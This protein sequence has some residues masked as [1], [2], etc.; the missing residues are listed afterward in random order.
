[1]ILTVLGNTWADGSFCSCL[2]T[3][4]L[5]NAKIFNDSSELRL[6]FFTFV[7]DGLIPFYEYNILI[8]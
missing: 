5:L 8:F 1:M 2:E 4:C 7:L 3:I 6:F